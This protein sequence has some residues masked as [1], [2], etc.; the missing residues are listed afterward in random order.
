ML[1]CLW[2]ARLDQ[3]NTGAGPQCSVAVGMAWANKNISVEALIKQADSEMYKD[4]AMKKALR[5]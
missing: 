1:I 3:L 4:K 5:E 2:K